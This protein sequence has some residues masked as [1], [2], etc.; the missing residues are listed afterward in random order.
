MPTSAPALRSP[1]VA[2]TASAPV[3]VQQFAPQRRPA[4]RL[5]WWAAC[6]LRGG[7]IGF[8]F[9]VAGTV[10]GR[11]PTHRRVVLVSLAAAVQIVTAGYYATVSKASDL[12]SCPPTAGLD[13][14]ITGRLSAEDDA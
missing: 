10:R 9:A 5:A 8:H 1:P 12:P 11:R 3:H 13:K 14:S 6:L 4:R 7:L 2:A